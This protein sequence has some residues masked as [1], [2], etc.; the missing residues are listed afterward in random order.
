[1]TNFEFMKAAEKKMAQCW[2]TLMTRSGKAFPSPRLEFTLKNCCA[3]THT[4]RTGIINLNM[5]FVA[6]NG[7]DMVDQ[8]VPHEVVHAWLTVTRDPSHVRSYDS[9]QG[10]MAIN[11]IYG[12]RTRRPKR[13][14]HG[15]TFMQTLASLGCTP[16]RCHNYDTSE[17][18]LKSQNRWDY[19]CPK[20]GKE[21]RLTT[22]LHNKIRRGQIRFCIPCG[23]V[24]GRLERVY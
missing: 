7:Q 19:K 13:N 11:R 2:A 3:G 12:I 16:T 5:A 24:N 8:T 10:W 22:C 15:D 18:K 23:S 4:G 20:C 9:M 21:Y 14:P 1:M 17:L 6:K